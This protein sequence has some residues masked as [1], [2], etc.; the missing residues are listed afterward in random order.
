MRTAPGHRPEPS[1][2]SGAV[3]GLQISTD[4]NVARIVLDRPEALNALAPA[5][6]ERLIEA[7][8]SLRN[9]AAV[10][11]VRLE[12][13]GGSFSAGAD[14]PAFLARLQGADPHFVAD[15]GRRATDA[16]AT[17]PQI[18][19]AGV[20][21]HCVGGGLVLA[22]ACDIRIGARDCRFKVPELDA[23]IPLAWGGF[24]QLVRLVGETVAADLVLSGRAF[25][26]DE[27]L[28]AGYLSRVVPSDQLDTELDALAK[29]IAMK[30]ALVLQ[31]TKQ[32]LLQVRADTFDARQDA[33]ALL[34]A[35][36]DEES[37]KHGMAY[38]A[39]HIEEPSEE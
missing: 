18:T 39:R 32:Q 31:I 17:L 34:S 4:G 30:P 16:L 33:A 10:K 3:T 6:L 27:A 9:D 29:E 26:A 22:G 12:G 8:D 35:F 1:C 36:R 20:H 24:A 38:I 15:L 28:V 14:L 5:T 37:I 23:G 11:V 21:G 13:A 19:V 7:C 25:G 2:K